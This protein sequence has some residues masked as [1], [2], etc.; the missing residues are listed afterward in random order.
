M[1]QNGYEKEV[2]PLALQTAVAGT[3]LETIA[4]IGGSYDE[5]KQEIL[6]AYGQTPEQIWHDL[7]QVKQGD[8]SF[9]QLCVR[10]GLKVAQFFDLARKPA[11]HAQEDKPDLTVDDMIEI[12]VKYLILEGCT[13]EL[14]THFL[15]RKVRTLDVEEFQELGV[16]FQAAHGRAK[17]VDFSADRKK[18]GSA[19]H[20]DDSSTMLAWKVEVKREAAELDK[21]TKMSLKE[22][23]SYASEER[24]CFNCWRKGHPYWNCRNKKRCDTCGKKHHTLLHLDVEGEQKTR[25]H[26]VSSLTETQTPTEVLLM[27]AAVQII[28]ENGRKF[29]TRAFL[30]PGAQASFVA[31]KFVE[32][33]GLPGVCRTRVAVQRFGTKTETFDTSIHEVK[34]VDAHGSHHSISAIKRSDLNL[35]IPPVPTKVVQRWRER[36]TEVSDA[37]STDFSE[38]WLLIGADY[39]NQFLKE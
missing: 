9:R 37:N 39:A 31:A 17:H 5:I 34:V 18:F 1:K 30:D 15:E 14:R 38:I 13:P 20:E 16:A 4:A 25:V 32:E 6:L 11:E 22:R 29:R 35:S 36:G 2:W 33:A 7:I 12:L 28:G 24:L 8:E 19:S 23:R 27:T 10:V 3:K 26:M 21:I